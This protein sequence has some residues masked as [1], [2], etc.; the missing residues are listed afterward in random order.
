M[1]DQFEKRP[2]H[3]SRVLQIKL[4][5]Q[6][7]GE[8]VDGSLIDRDRHY[9]MDELNRWLKGDFGEAAAGVQLH[10]DGL[11]VELD[12]QPILRVVESTANASASSLVLECTSNQPAPVIL[13]KVADLVDGLGI[14]VS[15]TE[16]VTSATDYT[17]L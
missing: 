9:L 13:T 3:V 5:K 6:G 17:P 2:G 14:T 16:L 11:D 4:S 10:E 12:P 7:D 8:T 15:G 1:S